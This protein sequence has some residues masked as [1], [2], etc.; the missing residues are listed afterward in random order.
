MTAYAWRILRRQPGTLL[1]A[2]VMTAVGAALITAFLLAYTSIESSRSPVQRYAATHIVVGSADGTFTPEVAR[3]IEALPG[4]AEVVSELT[5]PVQILNS[6]NQPVIDQSHVAQF[7]H[8]WQ[9]SVLSP[10]TITT[11]DIPTGDDE[12]ALDESLAQRAGLKANDSV[13]IEVGGVIHEVKVSGTLRSPN[14]LDYQHAV[15]FSQQRAAE[16]AGRG[17][18]RADALGVF[19][20]PG[21]DVTHVGG[22]IE[23]YLASEFEA[24]AKPPNEGTAYRVAWGA[25]RGELEG[26]IPSHRASAQTMFLLV[27]IVAFMSMAVVSGALVTSVRRRSGQFAVIRAVGATPGQVRLFCQ[28]E[29]LVVVVVGLAFGLPAGLLLAWAMVTLIRASGTISPVLT[30]HTDI[31]AFLIAAAVVVVVSQ[32]SA[33]FAARA[34]LR[35]RPGDAM[36]AVNDVRRRRYRTWLQVTAGVTA[37]LGA[38]VL[39]LVGMSGALPTAV[40]GNYGMIASALV[41]MGVALLG[42]WIVRLFAIWVRPITGRL[43]PFSGDLAAANVRYHFRRYAGVSVPMTI[44]LALAGWALA[45]LPLY[46]LSNAHETVD[47]FGAS[48]IAS[49]PVVRDRHTGLSEEA[50]LAVGRAAGVTSTAG[51]RETWIAAAR[52]GSTADPSMFTWGAIVDGEAAPLLNLGHVE[53]EMSRVDTGEGVA[54]GAEYA[55]RLGIDLFDRV[56]INLAG[57]NS[58]RNLPVVALFEED[59]NGRQAVVI[60]QRVTG[61]LHGKHWNDYII[62]DGPDAAQ[63]VATTLSTATVIAHTRADFLDHYVESRRSALNNLGTVGMGMVGLFLMVASVNALILGHQDRLG[64]ITALRRLSTSVRQIRGLVTAEMIITVSAACLLGMLAVFWMTYSMA[65]LDLRATIW[66]FPALPL[67]GASATILLMAVSGSVTAV[68]TLQRHISEAPT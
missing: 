2:I 63:A 55:D 39:Q 54:L 33:W 56:E 30:L 60:S 5:F 37:I 61:A 41:M 59:R 9:S 26:A 51:V 47:R 16:L 53:G 68:A 19:L 8:G 35:N 34:A 44:G 57:A 62:A 46:A 27:W 28:S 12:I 15:F 23:R 65:G 67:L 3:E 32:V 4:V 1:G 21:A 18:G 58:T 29:A 7:G 11:G 22:T 40:M 64:E 48:Y 17:F 31:P 43:A 25:D 66:A 14:G 42:S 20:S 24:V 49:T 38:G 6:W 13:A 10:L 45:G 36:G 52:T 50:L